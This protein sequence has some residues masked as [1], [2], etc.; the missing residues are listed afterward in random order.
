MDIQDQL[1]SYANVKENLIHLAAK[2]LTGWD[3]LLWINH[4]SILKMLIGG[5]VL[6]LKWKNMLQYNFLEALKKSRLATIQ[7]DL[8]MSAIKEW[9]TSLTH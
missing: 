8:K 3:Y 4:R 5:K 7:S 9:L 2:K 6:S 1:N